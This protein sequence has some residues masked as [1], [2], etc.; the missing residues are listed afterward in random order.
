MVLLN[1]PFFKTAIISFFGGVI[2]ALTKG[3]RGLREVVAVI[4]VALVAGVLISPLAVLLVERFLGAM[5]EQPVADAV[6]ALMAIASWTVVG[7]IQR[8]ELPGRLG[9]WLKQGKHDDSKPWDGKER[10]KR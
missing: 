2:A 3:V 1:I 9:V 8:G 5:L 4:V 7:H 6:T 10:R